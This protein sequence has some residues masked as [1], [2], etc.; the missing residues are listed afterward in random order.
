MQKVIA[1][2]V[3]AGAQRANGRVGEAGCERAVRRTDCAANRID[4]LGFRLLAIGLGLALL[5]SREL[6]PP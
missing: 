6:P 3:E 4:S 1:I 5:S 2:V